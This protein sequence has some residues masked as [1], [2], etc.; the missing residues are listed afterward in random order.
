MFL[1]ICA[2]WRYI[3]HALLFNRPVIAVARCCGT[4]LRGVSTMIVLTV[5][6]P[7]CICTLLDNIF[8]C[9]SVVLVCRECFSLLRS[10]L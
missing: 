4:C 5:V 10:T 6:S 7:G 3:D 2:P 8:L 9:I 1:A